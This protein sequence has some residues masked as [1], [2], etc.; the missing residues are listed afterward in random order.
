MALE[1]SWNNKVLG[2]MLACIGQDHDGKVFPDAWYLL[3][4][5]QK[6]T[7]CSGTFHIRGSFISINPFICNAI[8]SGLDDSPAVRSLN[9]LNC[10]ILKGGNDCRRLAHGS[11]NHQ[12]SVPTQGCFRFHCTPSQGYSLRTAIARSMK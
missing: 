1:I 3:L 9:Y 12:V 7:V 4:R 8:E 10:A 6:C 2:E 11:S 5:I